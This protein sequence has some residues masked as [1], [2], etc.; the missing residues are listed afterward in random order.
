[1]PSRRQR[2]DVPVA[3]PSATVPE[4]PL[5][6]PPARAPR[7]RHRPGGPWAASAGRALQVAAVLAWMGLL[8]L[9]RWARAAAMVLRGA[10]A[11]RGV[12]AT[13]GVYGLFTALALFYAAPEWREG[14][15]AWQD[16]TRLFYYP[17]MAAVGA[18][19]RQ[20]T[21]PLWSPALFGGYP[22][23]ADGGV[24]PLYPPHWLLLRVLSPEQAL[25]WLRVVHL[26]LAAA[27]T[28]HYVRMLGLPRFPAV[29]SGLSYAYAGFFAAQTVHA[30]LAEAAVW[31]PLALCGVEW[32]RRGRYWWGIALAGLALGVQGLAVHINIT[33]MS[34][35][36]VALYTPLVFALPGPQEAVNR[37]RA[38]LPGRVARRLLAGG[39]A[40]AAI[41]ATGF[42][43]S[44][45]QLLPLYELGTASFRSRGLPPGFAA[46]NSI[47]PVN[48]LTLLLPDALGGTVTRPGWGLWVPWETAI[49]VGLLPLLLA[50]VAWLRPGFYVGLWW[51]VA[52]GAL[53]VAFGDLGPWPL[54]E[55][56]RAL[57]LFNTLQSPGRFGLFSTLAVAVL[58]A[59]GAAALAAWAMRPRW[60]W[61]LTGLVAVALP[62]GAAWLALRSL[63]AWVD[64]HERDIG[65]W[66]QWYVSQPGAPRGL[67]GQPLPAEWI[68]AQL[69]AAV[70]WSNPAVAGQARLLVGGLAALVAWGLACRGAARAAAS[71]PCAGAGRVGRVVRWGE[72]HRVAEHV[73]RGTQAL[74]VLALAA[75]LLPFGRA[76]H[77]RIEVGALRPKLPPPLQQPPPL[78]QLRTFTRSDPTRQFAGAPNVLLPTGWEEF[79]GFSSLESDRHARY[80][81]QVEQTP[82][83]LLDL[84]GAR[85]FLDRGKPPSLPV[86]RGVPFHPARPVLHGGA[87]NPGGHVVLRVDRVQA[88]ELGIIS[89]L[90]GARDAPQD[91]EVGQVTVAAADG[92]T[93]TL[94]LR[95]GR[96]TAD[97]DLAAAPPDQ[98]PRHRA[99]EVAEAIPA[100]TDDGR[101][102]PQQ[103]Y[104]GLL[105]LPR[106]VVIVRL[107]V[108]YTWPSGILEVFGLAPLRPDGAIEPTP[109]LAK[110]RELYRDSEWLVAENTAA[111]PRAFLVSSARMARHDQDVL[112]WMTDGPFDPRRVALVEP[113]ASQ[114]APW[115]GWALQQ[116]VPP[117]EAWIE[118]YAPTEIVVRTR[119]A[120][121]GFLV[122]TDPY[123]PGWRAT[124]DGLATSI[125]RT[126][127]LFRG[128]FV[129]AGE[130]VVRFTYEPLPFRIGAVLSLA[131]LVLLT[132]GVL[133]R[134]ARG[135]LG[136]RWHRL[137]LA[138][139]PLGA[140]WPRRLGRPPAG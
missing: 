47:A 26:V 136:R 114:E 100:A 57:P 83:H 82:N 94:P 132:T 89:W 54:W 140:G 39:V 120:T 72:R 51:A 16:D 108:Q 91:A 117:G 24:G 84:L 115:P 139:V 86:Y 35:L 6:A 73:L 59:H 76:Y 121:D 43:L 111:L 11:A 109:P 41:G 65:A 19:L 12:L 75:D 106:R 52:V 131:T 93:F 23:L 67:D 125:Y 102:Y 98:P 5:A 68:H 79:T 134:A 38:W 31:L 61:L 53:L 97:R 92:A 71:A 28:Y 95:A 80:V 128:V 63:G 44:A 8:V 21:L 123:F 25:V 113:V 101:P 78:G 107:E 55:R 7:R 138:W 62:V 105:R 9:G 20:N 58:A 127:Y 77:P 130:R 22:L 119:S 135:W 64:A 42:G 29:L 87:A 36:L 56:L 129:P 3:P 70:D 10:L 45:V 104:Y 14:L 96:E 33:L 133:G 18:A 50:L 17:V 13:L 112:V 88:Q 118:R 2:P 4:A 74:V 27:F 124:V 137:R 48:L 34:G 69:R 32:A 85:Y 30:N 46:V 99:A 122:L 81:A 116:D 60:R 110:W 40:L 1:V 15:V 66:L 90:V 37:W 49:Y 103:R 126:D